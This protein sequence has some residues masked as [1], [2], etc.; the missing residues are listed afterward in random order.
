MN[1]WFYSRAHV[2]KFYDQSEADQHFVCTDKSTDSVTHS[3]L[4]EHS[5]NGRHSCLKH[6]LAIFCSSKDF[7]VDF[8]P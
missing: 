3:W 8:L 1:N 5:K 7:D 4:V 6:R 2:I